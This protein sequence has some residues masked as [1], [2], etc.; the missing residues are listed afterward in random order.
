MKSLKI[1]NLKFFSL[2]HESK[3][4]LLK[5]TEFWWIL[6]RNHCIVEAPTFIFLKIRDRIRISRVEKLAGAKF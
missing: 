2:I 5:I 3:E 4:I 1:Q 6:A